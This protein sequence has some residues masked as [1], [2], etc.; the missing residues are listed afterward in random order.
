MGWIVGY[1]FMIISKQTGEF[2]EN[3]ASDWLVQKMLCSY[4]K[5]CVVI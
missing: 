2:P 4:Q 1:V 3:K 5:V